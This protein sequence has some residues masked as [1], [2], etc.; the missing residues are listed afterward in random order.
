M[1]SFII[2]VIFFILAVSAVLFGSYHTVKIYD[3]L[4]SKLDMF[5]ENPESG[6]FL[7][8]ED[9]QKFLD[10]KKDYFFMVLPQEA[11]NEMYCDYSDT[12]QHLYSKDSDSYTASLAKTKLRI[13]QLR[14]NEGF[15]LY[16][17]LFNSQDSKKRYFP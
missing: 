14:K 10:S 9:T 12:V 1:R 6:D 8:V 11:I 5:P 17:V 2:A 16:E 7:I 4:L 15:S 13:K 3:E